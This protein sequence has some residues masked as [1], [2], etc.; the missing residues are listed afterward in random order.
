MLDMGPGMGNHQ[1]EWQVPNINCV[2]TQFSIGIMCHGIN[3]S[4]SQSV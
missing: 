1:H 3:E 2:Y 4:N